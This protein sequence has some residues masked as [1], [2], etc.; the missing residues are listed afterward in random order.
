[1]V[2]PLGIHY[3]RLADRAWSRTAEEEVPT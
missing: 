3:E 1:M 2:S